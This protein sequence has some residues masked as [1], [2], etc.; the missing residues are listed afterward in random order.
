MLGISLRDLKHI[1]TLTDRDSQN[2]N[3][4]T[5]KFQYIKRWKNFILNLMRLIISFYYL[6]I[7]FALNDLKKLM[8]LNSIMLSLQYFEIS[9]GLIF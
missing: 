2:F 1:R 5:L 9:L 7:C 8:K 4:V 6:I 3:C